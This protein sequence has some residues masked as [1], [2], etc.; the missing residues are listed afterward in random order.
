MNYIMP[1]N[2]TTNSNTEDQI[3]TRAKNRVEEL[4]EFYEHLSAY[5]FVNFILIAVNL[6]TA[7]NRLWF[8]WTTVFWGIGLAAHALRVWGMSSTFGSQ[9]RRE[10]SKKLLKK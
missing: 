7:P 6:V 8:Y 3:L 5:I 1:D 10:K 4:K 2:S 9:W